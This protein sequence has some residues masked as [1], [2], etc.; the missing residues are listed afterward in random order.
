M[1]PY[2]CAARKWQGPPVSFL[3][4][5]NVDLRGI[6]GIP[7]APKEAGAVFLSAPFQALDRVNSRTMDLDLSFQDAT[8]Q[9]AGKHE[10]VGLIRTQVSCMGRK[11]DCALHEERFPGTGVHRRTESQ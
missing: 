2:E 4:A 11:L 5:I 3:T 8:I 9:R 6:D 7:D 10:E 1:F